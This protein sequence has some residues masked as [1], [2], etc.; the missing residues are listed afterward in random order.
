MQSRPLRVRMEA[1]DKAG[2]GEEERREMVREKDGD[3]D[4]DGD[5]E[6]SGDEVG[7]LGGRRKEE[8]EEDEDGDDFMGEME[9][10]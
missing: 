2:L 5:V 7:S 10:F 4:G 9:G 1:A 3:E 6:M 8:E